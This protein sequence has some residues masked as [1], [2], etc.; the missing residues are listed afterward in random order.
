MRRSHRWFDT[1]SSDYD[2]ER[3]MM[4]G[5]DSNGVDWHL[6]K[7]VTVSLISTLIVVLMALGGG[8]VSGLWMFADVRKDV[9]VLKMGQQV[10]QDR[11]GRQ[12]RMIGEAITLLRADIQELKR[13]VERLVEREYG[14]GV[15]PRTDPKR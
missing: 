1:N 9:E 15:S 6:N 7:G 4:I 8:L 3:D 14:N 11:D 5:S 13:T 12:D 10:A 2:M